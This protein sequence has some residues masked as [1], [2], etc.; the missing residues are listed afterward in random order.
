MSIWSYNTRVLIRS[1]HSYSTLLLKH[2][3][4]ILVEVTGKPRNKGKKEKKKGENP[5]SYTFYYKF[6][7]TKRSN[8]LNRTSKR[9]RG[10]SGSIDVVDSVMLTMK[11]FYCNRIEGSWFLLVFSHFS[12]VTC[13]H[14]F[15]ISGYI[16]CLCLWIVFIITRHIEARYIE[17]LSRTFYCNFGRDELYWLVIPRTLLFRGSLNRGST[18][19]PTGSWHIRV[20]HIRNLNL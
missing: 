15:V 5:A 6:L 10:Q 9:Q 3:G 7:K 16:I 12:F 19:C 17:V 13:W 1:E 8:S 18:V 11:L 20:K 14:L 2:G 4:Q